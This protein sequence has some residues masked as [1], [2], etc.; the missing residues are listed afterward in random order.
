MFGGWTLAGNWFLRS[1]LPFTVVDNSALGT[2]AGYNY[3]GAIFASPAGSGPG[4]CISAVNSPCLST[5]QFAPGAAVTGAPTGFGT[6]A[7]NS[8]Y[9]PHFFD[10]DLALMK[11]IRIK[12][13]VTFSFGAQ[14]YNIFNHTNFDQPV[15]DISN[16]LF[17]T[18]IAEVAPPTGLLGAFVPGTAASPRF[19]EIKGV[20]RF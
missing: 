16:P 4:T 19:V 6:I 8:I 17:G 13:K 7:R 10:V 2:L 12:E 18:S 20:I 15:S 14:A 11:D 1:G 5:S 9:G 3:A